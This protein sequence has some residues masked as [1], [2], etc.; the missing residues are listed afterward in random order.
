MCDY[1]SVDVD[2]R[3]VDVVVVVAVGCGSVCVTRCLSDARV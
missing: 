1:V 2:T 3:V